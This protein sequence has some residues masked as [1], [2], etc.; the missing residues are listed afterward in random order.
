MISSYL[1][2]TE[3]DAAVEADWI[4]LS[5]SSEETLVRPSD[6]SR[7]FGAHV[8]NEEVYIVCID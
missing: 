4:Q 7:V 5:G 3:V 6:V 8:V 2:A 1:K